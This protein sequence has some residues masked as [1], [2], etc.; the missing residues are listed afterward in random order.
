[1]KFDRKTGSLTT[2][3]KKGSKPPGDGWIKVFIERCIGA[4]TGFSLSKKGVSFTAAHV[5]DCHF[6]SD[7]FYGP[8]CATESQVFKQSLLEQNFD[9][10]LDTG[11]CLDGTVPGDTFASQSAVY[12][13]IWGD[14]DTPRITAIGNHDNRGNTKANLRTLFGMPDNYYYQ[15]IGSKWR[16]VVLDST[17]NGTGTQNPY[18]LGT[19]QTTWLSNLLAQSADK[20][21]CIMSHVPIL[22]VAAMKWYIYGGSNPV[23]TNTWNLTVDQHVDTFG[24]QELFRANPCVKVCLSG[25]EHVYDD[26]TVNYNGND[27]RF[28]C[29]GAVAINWWQD[30]TPASFRH[31]YQNRGY[32]IM[33]FYEDGTVSNNLIYY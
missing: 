30:I 23:L 22:S 10:I 17:T 9:Y 32:S 4:C 14:I 2:F 5:T 16:I 1:V 26:C 11:D 19:T 18:L 27:V 33:R 20:Y 3:S 29:N 21:V 7:S 25:H 13:G 8:S 24:I 12:N 28:I 31:T 15:D 6:R